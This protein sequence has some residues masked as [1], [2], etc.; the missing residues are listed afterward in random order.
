MLGPPIGNRVTFMRPDQA[1]TRWARDPRPDVAGPIAILP[2]SGLRPGD[3]DGFRNWLS[4]GLVAAAPAAGLGST[5]LGERRRRRRRREPAGSRCRATRRLGSDE[6]RGGAPARRLDQSGPRS[7]HRRPARHRV[8]PT[9]G[10]QPDERGWIAPIVV[11][12]G[13][14]RR[15]LGSSMA[16]VSDGPLVHGRSARPPRRR[17]GAR[18]SDSRGSA[19]LDLRPARPG[20]VAG[21]PVRLS[22]RPLRSRR[23][24]RASWA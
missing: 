1:R 17:S 3:L 20:G 8:R 16:I 18:S 23:S 9:V 2:T 10:R 14:V 12:G 5:E 24:I 4:R 19:A 21:S 15:H 11:A 6:P 7:R 13:V 22:R